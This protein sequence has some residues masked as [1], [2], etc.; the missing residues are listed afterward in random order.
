LDIVL[1]R[2]LAKIGQEGRRARRQEG[3]KIGGQEGRK[4]RLKV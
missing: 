3:K 4:E 1:E 2:G